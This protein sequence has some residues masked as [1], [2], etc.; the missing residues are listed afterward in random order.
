MRLL[1]ETKMNVPVSGCLRFYKCPFYTQAL[2]RC[3]YRIESNAVFGA[4]LSGET[5][6]APFNLCFS[7]SSVVRDLGVITLGSPFPSSPTSVRLLS[8][9]QQRCSNVGQGGGRGAID[10][11]AVARGYANQHHRDTNGQQIFNPLIC[12]VTIM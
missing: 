3:P 1:R 7:F 2:S 9:R 8:D 11:Q 12:E 10:E 6:F 4:G 5:L